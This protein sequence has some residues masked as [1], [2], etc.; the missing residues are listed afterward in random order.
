MD[1]ALAKV[2]AAG[3]S[4]IAGPEEMPGAARSARCADPA[5]A[6]FRLWEPRGHTGVQRANEDGTWN[7]SEL[8][9]P[10]LEAAKAFYGAVFGWVVDTVTFGDQTG[11]MVRMPGYGD[12]LEQ[13]EPGIRERQGQA[14]VP[15]GYEDAV[16]WMSDLAAG[17]DTEPPR[18]GITFAVDDADAVAARATD[19]GGTLV[20]PPFDA[21]PGVRLAI[22]RDPA[23]AVFTINRYGPPA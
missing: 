15:P 8:A 14:G 22:L 3:G 10:D 18:W 13:F 19:L 23:G 5:G 9:T 7:M 6:A 11:Y 1:R 16:A 17:T 4:V 21:G 2:S 20:V 12:F